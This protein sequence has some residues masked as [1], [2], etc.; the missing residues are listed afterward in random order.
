VSNEKEKN[1]QRKPKNVRKTLKGKKSSG[2][3]AKKDTVS[4]VPGHG[5]ATAP[6][7]PADPAADPPADPL[8]DTAAEPADT[9]ANPPAPPVDPAQANPPP[10]TASALVAAPANPPEPNAEPTAAVRTD[11]ARAPL[12]TEPKRATAAKS[13]AVPSKVKVKQEKQEE[14]VTPVPTSAVRR[15]NQP[16]KT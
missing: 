7:A 11:A 9:P 4:T 3:R 13:M 2:W 8:A 5:T 14:P 6:D 1:H 16:W 15:Q 10:E 12:N